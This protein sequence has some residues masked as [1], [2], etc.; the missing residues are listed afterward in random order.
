MRQ[1]RVRTTRARRVGLIAVLSLAA[2]IVQ[3]SPA[4]GANTLE[5]S[6][7][8][9]GRLQFD[10]PLSNEL[11]EAGFQDRATGT[12]TGTLNGAAQRDTPVV[13]RAK[14]SGTLSCL[15]GH[16]TSS[17]TLAFTRGTESQADDVKISFFTDTSGGLTQ[18]ASKFEG[19]VSGEGIAYV[20]FLPSAD[21]SALAECEAGTFDSARYDLQAQTITPV[22][23]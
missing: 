10:P 14:G 19:A 1:Q 17:G 12:C 7:S 13:L 5:G 8:L 23:G 15:A 16:T 6:C 20:S 21:E 22:V 11:R 18:F 9:S 2:V 4:A 3:A